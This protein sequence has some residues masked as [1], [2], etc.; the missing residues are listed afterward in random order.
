MKKLL[1]LPALFS[2]SHSFGQSLP[3]LNKS[4]YAYEDFG[5]STEYQ[6]ITWG[7]PA[8]SGAHEVTVD[9]VCN[10]FTD[11]FTYNMV[12][13][14]AEKKGVLHVTQPYGQYLPVSLTFG[15]KS[16]GKPETLN[17]K[18]STYLKFTV[19]NTNAYPL[20]VFVGLLDEDSHVVDAI[21]TSPVMQIYLDDI[22]IQLA[23]GETKDVALDFNTNAYDA[24]YDD[25]QDCDIAVMSG[26]GLLFDNKRVAGAFFTVVNGMTAGPIDGYKSFKLQDATLEFSEILIGDGKAKAKWV[27]TG[28]EEEISE[29]I[30]QMCYPN[31]A[32][33]NLYFKKELSNVK[34]TNVLGEVVASSNSASQMPLNG[35]EKGVYLLS[36]SELARPVRVVVE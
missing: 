1:L 28:L 29:N 22:R 23:P 2:I 3:G 31:P 5:S 24:Q 10:K 30:A 33:N 18:G 27:T 9:S 12:R 36:S 25:M 15:H 32:T 35:I 19:K 14:P 26:K 17:L 16:N 13:V 34:L 11:Y 7:D 8:F 4:G 20:T 6:Y 21:G